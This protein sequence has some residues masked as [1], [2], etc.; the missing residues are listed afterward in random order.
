M[1]LAVDRDDYHVCCSG[2]KVP[3]RYVG[4]C[5]YIGLREDI[6]AALARAA[7]CSP[8]T[9]TKA[10]HLVVRVHF[11]PLGLA[12]YGIATAGAEHCFSPL[13]TKKLYPNDP[14]D[15]R[16]WH[17]HGDLPLGHVGP[18]GIAYLTTEWMQIV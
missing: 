16:V 1:F 8:E 11:T 14:T 9:V 2:G 15:W 6:G 3:L 7:L 10:T 4:D 5:E 17:F 13:L 18:G 12:H